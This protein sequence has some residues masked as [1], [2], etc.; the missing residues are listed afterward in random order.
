MKNT[1]RIIK[2]DDNTYHVEKR[3][4]LLFWIP[5][6]E[7]AYLDE[8]DFHIKKVFKT[9]D[10]ARDFILS[11]NKI[12]NEVVEYTS[13]R[14]LLESKNDNLS[15]EFKI[16]TNDYSDLEDYYKANENSYILFELKNNFYKK[17]RWMYEYE[18]NDKKTYADGVEDVLDKLS[19]LLY[20]N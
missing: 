15:Y 9:I 19:E 13:P 10:D 16:K 6:K 2:I 8:G 11:E 14:Q 3:H 5:I 4:L 17:C 1:Y 18:N 12:K 7:L 20:E